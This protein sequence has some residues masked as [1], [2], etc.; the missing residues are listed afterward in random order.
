M[1]RIA[2]AVILPASTSSRKFRLE[3]NSSSPVKNGA[4]DITLLQDNNL[5]L[6]EYFVEPQLYANHLPKFQTMLDSLEVLSQW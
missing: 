2:K 5:Y 4:L 1:S 3:C 6:I